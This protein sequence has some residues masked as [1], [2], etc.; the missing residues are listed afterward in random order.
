MNESERSEA[1]AKFSNRLEEVIVESSQEYRLTIAEVLGCL[2]LLKHTVIAHTPL[3]ELVKE[4]Q[5][6]GSNED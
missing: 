1:L 4:F 2:E 6:S 3:L 5:E